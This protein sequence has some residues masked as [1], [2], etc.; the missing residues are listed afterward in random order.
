MLPD[1][2]DKLMFDD[3]EVCFRKEIKPGETV[4]LEYSSD[5]VTHCVIIR[6]RTDDSVHAVIILQ[7]PEV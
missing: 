6:D 1:G 3:V 4:L 7:K 5:G 2:V